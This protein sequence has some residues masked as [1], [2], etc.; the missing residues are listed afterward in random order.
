MNKQTITKEQVINAL[1]KAFVDCCP[2]NKQAEQIFATSLTRD[3]LYE[4]GLHL[5]GYVDQWVE[6][7]LP[8]IL[9]QA[10]N[11]ISDNCLMSD[12]VLILDV[13]ELHDINVDDIMTSLDELAEP[14]AE[15]VRALLELL[16][17]S[18]KILS[19]SPAYSKKDISFTSINSD[20]K[21]AVYQW[22]LYLKQENG[23]KWDEIDLQTWASA[24][25]FWARPQ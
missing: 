22:L 3:E 12:M 15:D 23:Q 9:I 2:I 6:Y 14:D 8:N 21:K 18:E 4:Q 19:K 11:H 7:A 25:Q 24:I 16:E 1:N 5:V 17:N 20:Q 13:L 10:L